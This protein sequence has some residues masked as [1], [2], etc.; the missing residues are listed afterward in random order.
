MDLFPLLRPKSQLYT[1]EEL[2]LILVN[3]II[4]LALQDTL[5]TGCPGTYGDLERLLQK[6]NVDGLLKIPLLF[7]VLCSPC[8]KDAIQE[9]DIPEQS[10]CFPA[11]W[12]LYGGHHS[13]QSLSI[14]PKTRNGQ[15]KC[16]KS[17]LMPDS[18]T[19]TLS[20]AY[21]LKALSKY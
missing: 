15:A 5:W 21:V 19:Q 20:V 11:H 1:P 4:D 10:W 9:K 6:V 18:Q 7:K 14:P 17:S 12:P 2:F 8:F 3:N 13:W 16:V